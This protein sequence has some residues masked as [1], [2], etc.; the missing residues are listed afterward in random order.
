VFLNKRQPKKKGLRKKTITG[1]AA[2]EWPW[3]LTYFSYHSAQS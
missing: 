2:I 1:G 3:T